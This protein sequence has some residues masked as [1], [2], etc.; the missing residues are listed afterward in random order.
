MPDWKQLQVAAQDFMRIENASE[1]PIHKAAVQQISD[2]L[3]RKRKAFFQNKKIGTIQNI[4][5]LGIAMTY[6]VIGNKTINYFLF[7][8]IT[9]NVS[10]LTTAFQ[11][12]I[13]KQRGFRYLILKNILASE[14]RDTS[15]PIFLTTYFVI[16]TR[17]YS[18]SPIGIIFQSDMRQRKNMTNNLTFFFFNMKVQDI[19]RNIEKTSLRTQMFLNIIN[20]T[21]NKIILVYGQSLLSVVCCLATNAIALVISPLNGLP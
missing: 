10:H 21:I 5:L 4:S 20:L 15:F 11:V 7:G 17:N 19:L 12:L 6:Y 2:L 13:N 18:Q 14:N 1:Q 16:I 8:F 3:M 9:T